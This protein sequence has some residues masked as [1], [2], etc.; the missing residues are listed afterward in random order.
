MVREN[1]YKLLLVLGQEE[2]VQGGAEVLEGLVGGSKDGE[3]PRPAEDRREV[4]KH[5]CL[6]ENYEV[7]VGLCDLHDVWEGWGEEDA[8]DIVHDAVKAEHGVDQRAAQCGRECQPVRREHARR[9]DGCD[10]LVPRQRRGLQER[11]GERDQHH[12]Y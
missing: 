7:A 6:E 11:G 12:D 2:L 1:I 9:R 8:A 3:G 5:D 10:E 4:G